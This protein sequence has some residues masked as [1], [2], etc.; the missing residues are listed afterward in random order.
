MLMHSSNNAMKS[1]YNASW[2]KALCLF[3]RLNL[4]E[5]ISVLVVFV[6]NKK[7]TLDI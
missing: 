3:K 7:V 2:G 4:L 6:A 5:F 1:S